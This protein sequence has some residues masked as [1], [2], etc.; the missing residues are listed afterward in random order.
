MLVRIRIYSSEL[1][2]RLLFYAFSSLFLG[3]LSIQLLISHYSKPFEE[4]H[5]VKEAGSW[6][7]RQVR[8][9]AQTGVRW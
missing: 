8:P 1:A 2:C 9:P 7:R 6:A 5:V 4:K 3:V